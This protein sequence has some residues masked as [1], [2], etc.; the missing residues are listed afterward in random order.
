MRKPDL[1]EVLASGMLVGDGAMGTYLYQ[2]GFPVGISYEELNLT[3]PEVIADVHRSYYEA[4]ARL[5]ETNTFTATRERLAKFGLEGETEAINRKAVQI[6]R[7]AVGAD[8]YVAGTVGSIRA[9]KRKNVSQQTIKQDFEQ[10]IGVLLNE[11]VDALILETFFDL[12]EILI[13]LRIARSKSDLPIICQLAAEDVGRTTD[14]YTLAHSFSRLAAEGADVIGFNCRSGPNGMLRNLERFRAEVEAQSAVD[15]VGEVGLSEASSLPVSVFP[16]AGIPDYVDGKYTYVSTPDYFAECARQFADLGA[17]II[18]GCCGTTPEHV[19]A[20]AL[21]LQNYIPQK[22]ELAL[23]SAAVPV[24]TEEPNDSKEAVA[25]AAMPWSIQPDEAPSIVDTVMERHTVIVELDP[26]RDLSID[27]FMEGAEALKEAGVDAVTMADNS[28][29]VTRMSNL[30]L[31]YL[32]RDKL[33]IRPLVH[34]ACRDRNLIGT[35]SHMMGLDALG[36]NHVLAV[37]GD[38]AK[39]G[40]LPGSSSVYDLTSFEIIRMIKQLNEGVA[41]SGKP[42]KQKA[43]F[44]VGAAFNPNVKHLDKAV[45]RLERKIEAGADYIMTQPVY[46]A[47]LIHDIHDATKHLRIPIFLGIAPLASGGNAEYLH[48]EVPGIRLPDHVRSRMAGLRG[49][50]GRAMG[51]QIAKELLDEALPYFNGIYL[52]TPFMSYHM[53]AELTRYVW[54]KTNR[55]N[56]HL[57]PLSK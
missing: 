53:T 46:D 26:P 42:L 3:R 6:A 19:K 15:E 48:N 23:G 22:K 39:F 28:L 13:A 41:F 8:A 12:E 16:N 34:I 9:G 37:T 55:S 11:G 17:R 24:Q 51:V 1:R 52:M 18:G 20:M 32:L 43:Q 45:Q 30:A 40:D 33:G 57:S 21:A 31:G 29:A 7:G 49:E 56:F 10:Q 4:G 27:K 35:Q 50:E 5:I 54:E 2:L 25:S 36:I 14:G 44:V 38:P 47:A